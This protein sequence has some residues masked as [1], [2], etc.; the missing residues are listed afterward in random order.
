MDDTVLGLIAMALVALIF[1]TSMTNHGDPDG[2][3]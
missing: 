1:V 3:A 2:T